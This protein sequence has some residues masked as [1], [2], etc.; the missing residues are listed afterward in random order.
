M[1]K[2]MK[3]IIA[4]IS[5]LAIMAGVAVGGWAI[6]RYVAKDGDFAIEAPVAEDNDSVQAGESENNGVSLMSAKIAPEQYAAYG[7]SPLAETAYEITATVT[8]ETGFSPDEIQGVEFSV[9]WQDSTDETISEY[10]TLSSEDNV[11]RLTFLKAFSTPIV[12]TAASVL[13]PEVTGSTVFD[14]AKRV[15]GVN[16][17]LDGSESVISGGET[18]S[19]AMPDFSE[20]A[21]GEAWR[22]AVLN[23]TESGI[24]G[25]GTVEGTVSSLRYSITPTSE[26]INALHE[27]NSSLSSTTGKTYSTPGPN[28][29]AIS[30]ADIIKNT[31]DEA[32]IMVSNYRSSLYKAFA[33]ASE[34]FDVKLTATVSNLTSET[35]EFDFTLNFTNFD[36]KIAGITMSETNV[37]V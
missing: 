29:S 3:R 22:S 5:A 19:V 15:V 8:D 6:G 28:G 20:S 35:F 33:N 16:I 7:I 24:L 9:D 17:S 14:Y 32:L 10:V 26:L 31:M 36:L 18:V 2:T 21:T 30:F 37:V 25:E 23:L 11:A 4:G 12:L 13:D 1:T 27:A 34:H